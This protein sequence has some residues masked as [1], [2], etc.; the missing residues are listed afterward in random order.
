MKLICMYLVSCWTHDHH[1][2]CWKCPPWASSHAC[3][4]H[5]IFRKV[6]SLESHSRC[7]FESPAVFAAYFHTHD[8]WECTIG[9][10]L[11]VEPCFICEPHKIEDSRMFV[12]K[13]LEPTICHVLFTIR[14]FQLV[15]SHDVITCLYVM[16]LS[17]ILVM[18]QQHVLSFLCV[19]Y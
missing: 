4:W 3:I 12:K 1:S 6:R 8:L 18:R 7:S 9:R 17:C 16:T 10:G 19:Y 14:F 11:A 2:R 5:S 13:Y 15:D